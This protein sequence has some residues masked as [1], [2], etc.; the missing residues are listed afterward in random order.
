MTDHRI[1]VFFYGLFMDENLLHCHKV[2]PLC[3]RRA[4]IDNYTL[5]IGERATLLPTSGARAYGMVYSMTHDDLE[6]LYIIPGLQQY[7]PEAVLAHTLDGETL[8][9]LCYNL[10][11]MPP[12]FESNAEYAA[13]LRSALREL[14]FPPEYIATIL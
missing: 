10:I 11:Q 1:D 2:V 4:Y 7:R 6:K 14:D 13:H 5:R 8:P 3:P 12:H 9:A